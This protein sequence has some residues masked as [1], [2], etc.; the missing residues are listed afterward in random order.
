V[1]DLPAQAAAALGGRKRP[2][3]AVTVGDYTFRTTVAAYGGQPMI[4]IN[5]AGKVE[6]L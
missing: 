1:F 3:V 2:P 4:G 6:R 5:K